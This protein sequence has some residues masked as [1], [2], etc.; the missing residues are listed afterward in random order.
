[1]IQPPAGAGRVAAAAAG[2]LLVLS[3]SW[4]AAKYYSDHSIQQGLGMDHLLPEELAQHM[5]Y[6]AF[7]LPAVLLLAFGLAPVVAR[8]AGALRAAARRGWWVPLLAATW[9]AAVGLHVSRTVL[10]GAP[11]ADDEQAMSFAAELLRQGTVL[12]PPPPGPATDWPFY[13]EQF[14]AITERGRFAQ[15][16]LGQPLALAAGRA[17]EAEWL[18]GPLASAALAPALYA[19]GLAAFG[20]RVATLAVILLALSPQVLLTAGTRL[21][22]PLS[23]LCA[24]LALLA[25]RAATRADGPR[26]GPAALAGLALAA[27]FLVR[28]MPGALLVVAAAAWLAWPRPQWTPGR[29]LVALVSLATCAGLGVAAVLATNAAQTGHPLV[30]AYQ[31]VH[32]V[33]TDTS[34]LAR[35]AGSAAGLERR[36]FSLVGNLLRADLWFLGWPAS[37]LLLAFARR[38]RAAALP[39]TFLA[40]VLVYRVMTPK[41]GVSITGPVYMYEALPLFCLLAADGLL[42]LART[43]VVGPLVPAAA[44]AACFVSAALF[45]PTRL[46]DLRLQTEPR[47]VVARLLSQVPGEL[48]VFQRG[49]VPRGSSWAYYPPPNPPDF[50]GRV[51]FFR[52][53]RTPA[54]DAAPNLDFVRRAYPGRVPLYLGWRDQQ[55]VVMR[56]ENYLTL[57]ASEA[58]E[59]P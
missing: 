36:V 47:L 21:S 32:R 11:V 54:G 34:G 3:A 9:I 20:P 53:L 1:M 59:E 41:Q 5:L 58:P 4:T 49:L 35:I 7:G 38:T 15:Y 8:G 33:A 48:A 24:L 39:L 26:T 10:V 40:A 56:L 18:V 12:G 57:P 2:L 23:A 6:R 25:L 55:L 50:S 22:Q 14:V 43:R 45:V 27:A 28:P 17:L 29:R 13:R 52:L 37:L 44:L 51:L 16:S 42:R 19:L 46:N 30:S 31:V